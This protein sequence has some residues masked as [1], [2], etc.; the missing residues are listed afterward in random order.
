MQYPL[1]SKPHKVKL[2][3][4]LAHDYLHITKHSAWHIGTVNKYGLRGRN[5]FVPLGIIC[6]RKTVV[7]KILLVRVNI[8]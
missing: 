2:R 5:L 3:V 7:I 4:L 1:D 8:Y 6:S